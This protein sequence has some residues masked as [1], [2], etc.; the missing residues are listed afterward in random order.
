M[1]G[2]QATRPKDVRIRASVPAAFFLG[3]SSSGSRNGPP[4]RTP[5]GVIR[6]SGIKSAVANGPHAATARMLVSMGTAHA[7]SIKWQ[8]SSISCRSANLPQ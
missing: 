8:Q 6:D 4:I 2:V 3:W 7:R 1:H 5:L